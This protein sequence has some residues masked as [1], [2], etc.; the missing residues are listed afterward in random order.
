LDGRQPT[1]AES[2]NLERKIQA[3]RE[4]Y[5]AAKTE[6][7]LIEV[8]S[9]YRSER[10]DRVTHTRVDNRHDLKLKYKLKNNR[11]DR[12]RKAEKSNK[13]AS[14]RAGMRVITEE[15][16]FKEI[17]R[18]R[19]VDDIKVND[20]PEPEAKSNRRSA[21]LDDDCI[22]N[23]LFGLDL[24]DEFCYDDEFPWVTESLI[25]EGI[26]S[27]Y[28]SSAKIWDIF[29]H[30]QIQSLWEKCPLLFDIIAFLHQLYKSDSFAG[31]MACTYSFCRS[32]FVNMTEMSKTIMSYIRTFVDLTYP[33][34]PIRT[35]GWAEMS[36]NFT[37]FVN[38]ILSSSLLTG[39][40]TLIVSLV[41]LKIFNHDIGDKVKCIFGEVP[42]LPVV[43]FI[44]VLLE[45]I[46]KFARMADMLAKGVPFT[47][48]LLSDN[49]LEKTL[50][51]GNKVLH[52]EDH[53]YTG[54]PV[55]G[56][57]CAKLFVSELSKAVDTLTA[58]KKTVY[59]YSRSFK[60]IDYAVAKF[61]A[62][63]NRVRVKIDGRDRDMPV[64]ILIYGDPGIGK[65]RI[66][67]HT[68]KLW[69]EIKGR[70][71]SLTQ[72]YTRIHNSDYWEG[73]EPYSHPYI[74]YSELGNL[75]KSQVQRRGD[76]AID[77]LCSVIDSLPH[78]VNM[79]ALDKKGSVYVMPEVVVID[80]N[81]ESLNLD[82]LYN[83]PSAYRRRFI[84]IEPVVKQEFRVANGVALDSMKSI[85]AGGNLLDRWL[86]TV[87]IKIP[88]SNLVS[89]DDVILQYGDIYELETCLRELFTT[90]IEAQQEVRK[91]FDVDREE[92]YPLDYDS[93]HS[94]SSVLTNI[95]TQS[96]LYGYAYLKS[97][98]LLLYSY[99]LF[100]WDAFKPRLLNFSYNFVPPIIGCILC[101]FIYVLLYLIWLLPLG[102]ASKFDIK[103]KFLRVYLDNLYSKCC[104]RAK[105]YLYDLEKKRDKLPWV[106]AFLATSST[107]L[108]MY[109]AY[110]MFFNKLRTE[111]AV[112][113]F[114]KDGEGSERILEI[115]RLS[116]SDNKF[117]PIRAKI[118]KV[119]NSMEIVCNSTMSRN[120]SYNIMRRINRNVVRVYV[121][122]RKKRICTHILG[123]QGSVAICN[124]HSLGELPL[125]GTWEIEFPCNGNG[126]DCTQW[127][128]RLYRVKDIVAV[129]DDIV[130][131]STNRNFKDITPYITTDIP[132]DRT[133][134]MMS[135][136]RYGDIQDL[137]PVKREVSVPAQARHSEFKLSKHLTYYWDN[138]GVSQCGK[139][140]VAIIDGHTVVCGIHMA[141]AKGSQCFA[142]PF[143]RSHIDAAIT[144]LNT[145]SM[146]LALRSE[147]Q[148]DVE[149]FN[150]PSRKSPFRH[151]LLDGVRYF[152]ATRDRICINN[153]SKVEKSPLYDSFVNAFPDEA[154]DEQKQPVYGPPP[155][156]PFIDQDG[157]Y[158]SPYNIALRKMSI[159]HKGI[160]MTPLDKCVSRI[161]EKAS[162]LDISIAPLPMEN[163][164]NGVTGTSARR[165]NVRTG[166]GDQYN[167]K[168]YELLPLV[169]V[170]N[171]IREP[172]DGLKV[173][174]ADI[175]SLYASGQT[176]GFKYTAQLKDEIRL[177]TKNRLGKTRVF[178]AAP[179]DLLIVQRM[180]I[181]P[182]YLAIIPH[183]EV[184][185]AAVGIDMHRGAHTLLTDLRK[186]NDMFMEGDYSNFDQT[187]PFEIRLAAVSV[188]EKIAEKKGYNKYALK[189]LRGLL[190]EELFPRIK[191][192]GDV[193][194]AP[195]QTSGKLGTAENNSIIGLLLMMYYWYTHTDDDF[196]ENVCVR[197]YGDD[198]LA[199][200]CSDYTFMNNID[201]SEF[202]AQVYGMKFTPAVKD[203]EMTHLLHFEDVSFLQRTFRYHNTLDR[204]VAP[205]KE[206]VLFK[207]GAFLLPSSA[208]D[209]D[210][211]MEQTLISFCYEICLKSDCKEDYDFI[212]RPIS[213]AFYERFDRKASLP[214]YD[215]LISKLSE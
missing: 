141:S 181:Y 195:I 146:Y 55:R 147:G 29:D 36:D 196:Y 128:S 179:I 102:T 103:L 168:K 34:W 194:E 86:F 127:S 175:I 89:E 212:I 74:H 202:C 90:H 155:L 43:D 17:A 210:V 124:K 130:L 160:D 205:L 152:G 215:E 91:N 32:F 126:D 197:T 63:A 15:V 207:M 119:W 85:E 52:M 4:K 172:D 167:C 190:T 186:H 75:K 69:S 14:R 100:A 123:I 211:Q 10:N 115:E 6:S 187:I 48:Y 157:N 176:C 101:I 92:K 51:E 184:F 208:L 22:I 45:Q 198:I 94:E 71:F 11:R 110:K 149:Q 129:A 203:A 77:E 134:K 163:A 213:R 73:Y 47:E 33:L 79:A 81:N 116:D 60:S 64:G 25:S 113:S 67:T 38:T 114:I 93:L 21:R 56:Q 28:I 143:T 70:P 162:D 98:V 133:I 50:S 144:T 151:E 80:T 106:S 161:L 7:T 44:P 120:D 158:I 107:V 84:Y 193:F 58:L 40:R 83:N 135:M 122:E 166:A 27:M 87:K 65:S 54:L 192:N 108:A 105:A 145:S 30:S 104:Y 16:S 118:D 39:I 109:Y 170:D 13:I 59:P 177:E 182:I 174:I 125:T 150:T 136:D 171:C 12:K 183:I 5:F 57:M 139:P 96:I 41:S 131:F 200:S 142:A 49:P 99:I 95:S 53:L 66:L 111:G 2:L 24:D 23:D 9:K 201:Y 97:Y 20:V 42:T 88:R 178:Y 26:S 165:I 214:S 138:H 173:R 191:M 35:E 209:P 121:N 164:I 154:Y 78:A 18:H 112:S 169:D 185:S 199:S 159:A 180:Y 61:Q 156:K 31:Y 153:T 37:V 189:I 72:V 82:E 137:I 148:I 19:R 204:W 8:R 188:I 132:W 46:S 3:A 68:L 76:P 117:V 62:A 206:T 140:V 1:A